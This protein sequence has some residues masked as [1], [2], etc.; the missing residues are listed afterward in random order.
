MSAEPVEH[1]D[2]MLHHKGPWTEAEWLAQ[3]ED[4]PQRTE[5]IDGDLLMSPVGEVRHQKLGFRLC[6]ELEQ[7]LPKALE[8]VHEANVRLFPRRIVIPDVLVTR[9]LSE[10]LVLDAA[11]VLLVAEVVSTWSKARDRIIKPALCAE[12]SIPWYLLVEHKPRLEL[13]LQRLDEHGYVEHARAREG[14]HL[15]LPDLSVTLEVAALLRR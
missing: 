11:D 8:A 14:E 2:P 5:L 4:G 13:V 3:V 10:P 6:R 9:D 15:E 1:T 12:A 7:Q